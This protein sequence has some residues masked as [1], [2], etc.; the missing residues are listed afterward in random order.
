MLIGRCKNCGK[1]RA[2]KEEN[3]KPKARVVYPDGKIKE[4]LIDCQPEKAVYICG[5]G[6]WCMAK[7]A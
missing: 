7:L 4:W 6:T 1:E 2:F 3:V 5:C